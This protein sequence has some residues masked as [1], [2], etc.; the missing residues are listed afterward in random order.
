MRFSMTLVSNVYLTHGLMLLCACATTYAALPESTG[1]IVPEWRPAVT[2]LLAAMA[3]LS[4]IAYPTW[5][6]LKNPGLWMFAILAAVAG[7]A[8]GYWL[9][10]YDHNWRLLR[11]Q[12]AHGCLVAAAALIGLSLIEIAPA[13]IGP[14]D[15]P[16]MELGLT[17]IASFLV[18]RSATVLLRSR[19]EP[20][21]D[22]NDSPAPPA[23][24]G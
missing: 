23:A 11:P 18:G 3:A 22:L 12:K 7:A 17:V 6:E 10:L 4:L 20:Q 13:A 21:S 8:R 5:G 2:P 24:E 19:Q 15:Q 1:R 16:T 9:R 14:A